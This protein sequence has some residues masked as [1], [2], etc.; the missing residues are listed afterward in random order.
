MDIAS[1][2][3]IVQELLNKDINR[4]VRYLYDQYFESAVQEIKQKGGTDEDAA[5]IFQ[6]AVLIVIDKV[7]TGQF[8]GESS[9][10]TFLI[11]VVRKL[12]LYERRSRS[13]RTVR[14]QFYTEMED[15]KGD[16]P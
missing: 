7:K 13:R 16:S 10:K 6:E 9:I 4:P 12:W 2:M 5:D 14:E 15:E 11:G 8:R 3:D 1:Q